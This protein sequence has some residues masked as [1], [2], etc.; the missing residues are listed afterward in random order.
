MGKPRGSLAPFVMLKNR[1]ANVD[2]KYFQYS[3]LEMA[4]WFAAATGSYTTVYLQSLGFSP[5]DVG[6]ISAL[7]SAISIFSTPFWGTMSDRMRSVKRVFLIVVVISMFLVPLIPI[8]GKFSVLGIGLPYLIIPLSSFFRMPSGALV[9]T[10]VVQAAN[11]DRLNYGSIRLWGS[12]TFAV[13]AFLLSAIMPVLGIQYSFYFYSFASLITLVVAFTIK[14]DATKQ[15]ALRFR[16]LHVGRLFKD[17][18][19]VAYLIFAITLNMPMQTSFTFMPYLI[20]AVNADATMI[21]VISGLKALVEVPLLFMVARLRTRFK[22]QHLIMVAGALYVSEAFLLSFSP[23]I[24]YIIGVSILQ[25]I[26]QGLFIGTGTN[27]VYRLAPENLKATAQTFNGAMNSIAG[28]VGN[29]LGGALIGIVG[30]KAF[31]GYASGMMAC[32]LLFFVF[33]FQIGSKL[34]KKPLP[35]AAMH[36]RDLISR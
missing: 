11:K 32:A 35:E 16:D 21:G 3:G 13:M 36:P 4:Y 8:T 5:A 7:N 22:I 6:L 29:L 2:R 31:F 27:Y 34:L 12:I 17:Y 33:S 23:N 28:I 10:W 9:D 26:A 24:G 30:I 25:G 18:Y 14:E 15:R 20:G 19:Y 1:F